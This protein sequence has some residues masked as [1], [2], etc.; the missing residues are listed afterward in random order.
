MKFT[1]KQQN[2][3]NDIIISRRDVRGNNFLSK[4]IKK[5]KLKKI[6]QSGLHAPSV[7]FSQPWKFVV[8][9]NNDTKQ[10]VYDDFT[11]H[12]EKSK[13]HFKG[14]ELYNSLKLEGIK[15]SPVNIAVFYKKP[16]KKVLGQTSQK[17][18]GEYS[19][20]CAI[21]NMWLMARSLNIGIGWVSI[22][23]HKKVRKILNVSD[24][25]KLVGYL[26]VGYTKQ[27]L[28][29]PE[30]ETLKW[31]KKKKLKKVVSFI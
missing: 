12:Y 13:K 15:E 2:I 27:F 17:K 30:L 22:I 9:E 7:G 8:I 28:D 4:N 14:R 10:K 31:E 11:S 26:C 18:M 24:E 21:Q 6:L 16:K 5:K 1:K 23:S 19:V 25:Y 29:T 20:V 3:L